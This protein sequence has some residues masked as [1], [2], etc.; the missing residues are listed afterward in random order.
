MAAYKMTGTGGHAQCSHCAGQFDLLP[1][2]LSNPPYTPTVSCPYC[3]RENDGVAALRWPTTAPAHNY[4]LKQTGA[5]RW[6]ARHRVG[7]RRVV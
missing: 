4:R 1:E 5:A 6:P 3:L 2:F 7:R